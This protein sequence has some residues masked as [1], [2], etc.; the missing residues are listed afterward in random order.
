MTYDPDRFAKGGVISK[1]IRLRVGEGTPETVMPL[2][3]PMPDCS[4]IAVRDR[5][6]T[7][8]H[9][10]GRGRIA[11]VNPVLLRADERTLLPGALL[12]L[13]RLRLRVV[14]N[15][16]PGGYIYVERVGW[17]ARV[18]AALTAIR[19]RNAAEREGSKPR[20]AEH[21]WDYDPA[22]DGPWRGRR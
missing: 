6:R 19:L 9:W 7:R 11:F 13:G 3:M 1:P 21:A 22:G 4:S 15:D 16:W 20:L 14:R 12:T 8:V 17:R 18:R 2:A 5:A 10:I